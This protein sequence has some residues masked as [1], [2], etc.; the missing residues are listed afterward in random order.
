MN[1]RDH[2]NSILEAWKMSWPNAKQVW[3]PFVRL[4][5]PLW[6]IN[7]KEAAREGLT[8]SFAMIRLTDHRI[9]IDI[10]KLFNNDL[11]LFALEVLAHEIGHHIYSPANLHDNAILLSKIRW[12]LADIEDRAPF[13]ANLYA[14]LLINDT[15]QRI[16]GL[17]M[18]GVYKKINDEP[19][20]SP[21]WLLFMRTYEYLWK[22][23]KG[24][25]VNNK[26]R[27]SPQID[28][29]ASVAASLIRSYSKRWLEGA[30]R[31]GALLYPYLMEEKDYTMARKSL[32]LQLDSENAGEGGG[33]VIGLAEIDVD[34]IS[35]AV[36]PRTS[37]LD[38][39]KNSSSLGD[40]AVAGE[41]P[42]QRYL[43]PG[44]YID[45][46]KQVNPKA[47]EQELISNYYK[48]IAS[49]HLVKFPLETYSPVSL[50]LPE[51]TEGWDLSDPVEEID[52]IQTA[53]SS[54][55]TLPGY[56][57]VKRVYGPDENDSE[58]P[59]PLDV[60]IGVDCSGSML[61]PRVQ[62]SWPIL[63]ATIIGLSALRAGAKV[64]GCLSGEPGRF[65]ESE[66]FI[67]SEK[68]ILTVLT[69]YLGTGYSFG[70]PRLNTPFSSPLKTRSHIVLV[71]DDDIFSM[72]D[73]QK[74]N[75]EESNW[76]I[77]ERALKNAGGV[78]SIVLHSNS[79][80]REKEVKRLNGMGWFVYFVTNEQQLL[81][82]AAEFSKNHYS[83]KG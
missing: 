82:F 27:Y 60:Y 37:G 8:E 20:N 38:K 55:I 72:L 15:L 28:A 25:L 11:T 43:N 19:S 2:L 45:L 50:T 64:M 62:F 57:I 21:M 83:K 46:Q 69:S 49:P 26:Y 10:E 70:I 6:C 41:G 13:V 14:D 31:F 23:N 67:T 24:E 9:V 3:N 53:I 5:E 52:W 48:E 61:N 30:G 34:S 56:N 16:K 79:E 42:K 32:I 71:S 59:I 75:V 39:G 54:P 74:E 80:W 36:D 47:E 4:R 51:G 44:K 12:S 40:I 22:M 66:G 77:V 58:T 65:M 1:N 73:A 29:D 68:D 76:V 63:A 35:E 81:D 33:M 78:G 18:A 7:S 17:N